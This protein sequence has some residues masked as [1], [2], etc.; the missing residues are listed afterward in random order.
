MLANPGGFLCFP[1]TLP[2]NPALPNFTQSLHADVT[3]EVGCGGNAEVTLFADPGIG[4]IPIATASM[5]CGN[6]P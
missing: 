5:V 3:M 2:H 4:N 1:T 6:C